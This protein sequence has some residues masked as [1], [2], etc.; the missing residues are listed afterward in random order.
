MLFLVGCGAPTATPV[1][2]TATPVPPTAT[3]IPEPKVGQWEGEGVSFTVTE[4]R[5][6]RD[7]YVFGSPVQECKFS[8]TEDLPIID[9][10]LE[11]SLSETTT[12]TLRFET[13]VTASASYEYGL[14]P[15]PASVYLSVSKGTRTATWQ[16]P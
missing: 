12:V 15:N 5:K 11:L 9:R 3:P 13:D 16:S 8:F 4:E 7:F 1:P 14:C 2:P 6:I 10:G